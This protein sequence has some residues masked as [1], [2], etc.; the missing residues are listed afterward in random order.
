MPG[1]LNLYTC[2][3]GKEGS[4]KETDKFFLHVFV[5]VAIAGECSATFGVA[6]ERTDKV[7]VFNFLVE[8]ASE[9]TSGEVATGYLVHRTFLPLQE[10]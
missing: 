8:V 5:N 9:V 1:K 10:H 3:G 6:A 2:G 4:V 7:G